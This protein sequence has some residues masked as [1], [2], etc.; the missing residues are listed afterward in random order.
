MESN[1]CFQDYKNASV[2]DYFVAKSNFDALQETVGDKM[3]VTDEEFDEIFSLI[4]QDPSEHF[5]LFDCWELG[6]VQY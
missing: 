1:D 3:T 2:D 5:K 6:K 4:C